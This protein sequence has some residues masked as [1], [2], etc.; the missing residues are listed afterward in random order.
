MIQT[1]KDRQILIDN[2][3]K[4]H[5]TK[6]GVDRLKKNLSLDTDDVVEY[7]KN[8]V[9]DDNCNIYRQGK[10]GIAKLII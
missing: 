7:C 10:I 2:I 9:L 3:N 8:K 6:M 4:L 5:T 1:E